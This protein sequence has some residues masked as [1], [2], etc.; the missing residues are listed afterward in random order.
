MDRPEKLGALDPRRTALLVIDMQNGFV[1]PKGSIARLGL[2]TDR[3]AAAVEPARS[4]VR[5]FRGAGAPVIFT[6]TVFR[7]DHADAGLQAERFPPLHAL[8][9]LVDGTWDAAL[10]DP[11]APE[12]RD[13]VIRK[14]RF[15]AFLGTPL[16]LELRALGTETLVVC[17]VATNV[18]VESTV[19]AAFD[20][21][22]RVVLAREATASYTREMEEASLA[23]VGFMFARVAAVEEIAAALAEGALGA[24]AHA[25]AAGGAPPRAGG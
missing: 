16:A 8:G 23:T 3:T 5:A 14:T 11:L 7:P 17:G 22:Y 6:Q 9:H 19:W 13:R 20:R 15:D 24:R 10:A 2:P 4:L 18:C 25:A 12:P 1:S 21:G